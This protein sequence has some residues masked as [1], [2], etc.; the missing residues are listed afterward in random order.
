MADVSK[1]SFPVS[2]KVVA[3]V[4][5]N[6][7]TDVA[8]LGFSNCVVAIVTQLASVGSI[9]Q[10]VGMSSAASNQNALYDAQSTVEQ[11]ATSA[12][13]PIEVKFVLGNSSTTAAS[14]LYQ[15][16]AT[17]I[18]Q[19][20]REQDPLDDRPLILG[21]GLELPREYKTSLLDDDVDQPDL[22]AFMLTMSAVA[23]LVDECCAQ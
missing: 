4:I 22:G 12:D 16:L 18:Y 11:L 8:V 17:H 15:V 21:V 10:A 3:G 14:S 13:I 6:V 7:H 1:S 19:H 5:A 23:A 2:A 20:R 9:I